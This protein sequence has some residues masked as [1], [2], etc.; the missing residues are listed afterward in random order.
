MRQPRASFARYLRHKSEPLRNY[1][2][3][4]GKLKSNLKQTA[5]ERFLF[6]TLE[7]YSLLGMA[8]LEMCRVSFYWNIR[9][10][11]SR[12]LDFQLTGIAK[13]RAGVEY[14]ECN[15]YLTMTIIYILLIMYKI[16]Y[17]LWTTKP[18]V[19]GSDP[20]SSKK[21]CDE[22]EH[23]YSNH[24]WHKFISIVYPFSSRHGTSSVKLETG[25]LG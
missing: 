17:M 2:I 7:R 10:L 19:A 16:G 15:Y 24:G 23:L 8:R 12:L 11:S 25:L 4:I 6:K 9:F 1:Q 14:S 20:A 22:H 21:M 5:Y 3:K 18:A 13:L